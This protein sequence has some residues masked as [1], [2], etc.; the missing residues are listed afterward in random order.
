MLD[1][2]PGVQVVTEGGRQFTKYA[3]SLQEVV[4]ATSADLAKLPYDGLAEGFYLVGSGGSGVAASLLTIGGIYAAVVGSSAMFIRQPAP[5]HL[6]EGNSN[7][8]T[9]LNNNFFSIVF[10]L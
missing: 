8:R 7:N 6:P 3:G 10:F 2:P 1:T 9:E 5:G 4:Y